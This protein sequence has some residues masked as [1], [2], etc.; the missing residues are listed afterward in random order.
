MQKRIGKVHV[1][2]LLVE[3]EVGNDW[4]CHVVRGD[5]GVN[6]E[7]AAAVHYVDEVAAVEEE[8]C[9]NFGEGNRAD[10]F[11]LDGEERGHPQ[12]W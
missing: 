11:Q 4:R 6:L 2:K 8:R 12:V 1:E 7:E 9:G 3:S 10:G 5:V